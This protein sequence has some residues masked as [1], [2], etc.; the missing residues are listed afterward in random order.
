MDKLVSI[1]VRNSRQ[2]VKISGIRE[3]VQVHNAIRILLIH[4]KIK[5]EPINPAPPVTTI[6]FSIVVILPITVATTAVLLRKRSYIV[7]KKD[8]N[9]PVLM[10]SV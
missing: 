9:R 6:V 7:N 10:T 3:L 5:F 8:G 2:I 1:I 4:R